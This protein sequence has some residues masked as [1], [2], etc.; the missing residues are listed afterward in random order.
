MNNP[1]LIF[2]YY[3]DA[4]IDL[5]QLPVNKA[6]LFAITTPQLARPVDL[7]RSRVHV[8]FP[9]VKRVNIWH[10]LIHALK[11]YLFLPLFILTKKYFLIIAPPYFHFL[12][13]PFLRLFG[14]KIFTIAGDA[15]SEIAWEPLWQGSLIQRIARKLLWPAYALSEFISIALSHRTFVVSKYLQHKYARWTAVELAPNG[16][17]VADIER[18]KP[19]RATPEQY[20]YYMGGLIKW[21]GIDILIKAFAKLK[22]KYDKPLKL[23]I[24]GGEKWELKHYP[25]L[26]NA[27]NANFVGKPALADAR[28]D[29]DVIFTGRLPHDKAIACLKA[30][31]IAVLPNRESLLS[32]TISSIKVFEYIAAEIP[33]VCTDTGDHA[34][35]VRKLNAG[36]VTKPTAE[37]IAEGMLRLLNDQKMYSQFKKNCATKKHLIDS[38]ALRLPIHKAFK[39]L[40]S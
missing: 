36:L 35:W 13:M 30:A 38:S 34:D 14:K 32:R 15:Y 18:I 7:S 12:A 21:R 4:W 29:K 25:E 23:V 16:A 39:Q 37:A 8:T 2:S 27:T 6:D 26:K 17:P 40:L 5:D 10:K 31:K 22:Q 3:E 33:Q 28:A 24:V 19:Q 20:I 9:R 11:F 1:L